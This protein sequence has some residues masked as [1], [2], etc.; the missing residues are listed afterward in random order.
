MKMKNLGFILFAAFILASCKKEAGSGCISQITDITP[1][2]ASD[3]DTIK[4]LI[5]NN[6]FS[7]KNQ[8]FTSYSSSVSPNQ[9]NQ[10]VFYQGV[11]AIQVRNGLPIFYGW[12]DYDFQNGVLQ[13]S[14][15]GRS[16]GSVTLDTKSTQTL[17]VLRQLF[18]NE[19]VNKQGYNAS[20]KDSCYVAQL[21]YYNINLNSAT[22]T[23][24]SFI[25]AWE[26]RPKNSQYPQ[27]YLRDD[28]GATIYLDRGLVLDLSKRLQNNR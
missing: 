18:I 2:S 23:T 25:K 9:Q 6:G 22:D 27:L 15:F 26:I 10:N 24:A 1:V 7:G 17:P 11:G 20:F 21:G 14:V 8:V 13:G 16:Y 28:N 4:T 5:Q 12:L 3:E 19:A